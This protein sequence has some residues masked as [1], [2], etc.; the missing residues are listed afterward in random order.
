MTLGNLKDENN[1][2]DISTKKFMLSDNGKAASQVALDNGKTAATIGSDKGNT[3][4]TVG[5][6]KGKSSPTVSS[7]KRKVVPTGG[8]NDKMDSSILDVGEKFDH[9]TVKRSSMK[10][11]GQHESETNRTRPGH[12]HITLQYS[13]KELLLFLVIHRIRELQPADFDSIN[14]VRV[15]MVSLPSKRLRSK[16]KFVSITEIEFGAT[17]KF[18][19]VSKADLLQSSMRFRL[20]G[21]NVRLGMHF[22]KDKLMGEMNVNL[23]D[24]AQRE[25]ITTSRPFRPPSS[26]KSIK[27]Y[28]LLDDKVNSKQRNAKTNRKTQNVGDDSGKVKI[29]ETSEVVTEDRPEVNLGE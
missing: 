5:S 14:Q 26:T 11:K 25:R 17:F 29:T 8:D 3:A 9:A 19:S 10:I 6:D 15:S 1:A 2:S 22:G 13:K 24:V 21:R 12:L 16:T 27:K 18:L 4:P 7:D 20:Y 28:I 23:A